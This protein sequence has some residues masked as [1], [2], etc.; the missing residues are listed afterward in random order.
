[1]KLTDRQTALL[2]SMPEADF[3][4]MR[5]SLVYHNNDPLSRGEANE[6][7]TFYLLTVKKSS[8]A[9]NHETVLH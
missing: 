4:A 5:D 3:E 7:V 8:W 1:M 6:L 2:D 9:G